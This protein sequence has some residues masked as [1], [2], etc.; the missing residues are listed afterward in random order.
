MWNDALDLKEFYATP[1]GQMARHLLR[2][3]LRQIWPNLTG[4]TVLGLGYAVPYLRQFRDE[5]RVIGLMPAAQGI[6]FWPPEGPGLTALVDETDL[7]LPDR[8]VDR[9]LLVHGLECSD[10]LRPLLREA[11]RVL[12]DGGRLLVAVP[13][14]SGIW[15]RSERTPFGQGST[16]SPAQ[17]SRLL[18]DNLFQPT[19]SA[20]A[21]FLPPL[22]SKALLKAGPAWERVG[23]RWFSR[24]AGVLLQ[25]AG[26]QIYGIA[27]AKAHP[28][29]RA[30]VLAFPQIARREPRD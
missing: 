2:R 25:E 7:P 20:R 22:R 4:M 17:L 18:R 14:R 19:E 30:R 26:K 29:R 6:V 15:A 21:L 16:Y 27:Q 1:L 5:A 3:R 9:L 28:R 12:S 8:S 13:N 10:E 23:E 24:F 11:W